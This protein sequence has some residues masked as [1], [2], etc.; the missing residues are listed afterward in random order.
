MPKF[1]ARSRERERARTDVVEMGSLSS[2]VN[3]RTNF[4]STIIIAR[5]R[6]KVSCFQLEGRRLCVLYIDPFVERSKNR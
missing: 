1:C 3:A 5:R 4:M 6:D 2:H